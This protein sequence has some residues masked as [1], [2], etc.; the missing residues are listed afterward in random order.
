MKTHS[1]HQ[2]IIRE[3]KI[4]LLE[5]NSYLLHDMPPEAFYTWDSLSQIR[6]IDKHGVWIG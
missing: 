1:Q 3:R 4:H 6:Y 5:S 2:D